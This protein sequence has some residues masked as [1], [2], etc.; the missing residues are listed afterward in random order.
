VLERTGSTAR[1]RLQP[2]AGL[3]YTVQVAL[4]PALPRLQLDYELENMGAD[5]RRVGIWSVLA[6]SRSGTIVAPFGKTN[7]SRKRLVLPWW[8]KWPHPTMQFGRMA[9]ASPV[10]E[11]GG[12]YKVGVIT[13]TGWLAFVRDGKALVSYVPFD[14]DAEYPE[15]GANV[16]FFESGGDKGWREIEQMSP[17]RDVS[18]GESIR[19]SETLDLVTLADPAPADPD[20]LRKAIEAQVKR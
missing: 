12:V 13:E 1:L 15:D 14:A 20:E 4:D 9:A 6:F 16:T 11:S 17:L 5:P 3:R 19:M 18:P 2:A 7:T 8:S 10:S